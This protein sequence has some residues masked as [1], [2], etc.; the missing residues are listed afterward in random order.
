MCSIITHI[1]FCSCDNELIKKQ[2]KW[3]IKR[4]KGVS[5]MALEKGRCLVP[6]YSD[7]LKMNINFIENELNNNPDCFDFKFRP[8]Q[9]DILNIVLTD[10]KKSNEFEFEFKDGNWEKS[11]S[12]SSHLNSNLI[13][14]KGKIK[15]V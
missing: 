9:N 4:F 1:K 5:W 14:F 11:N 6:D 12:I 10:S 8:I 3:S 15:L 13:S 2:S 7:N